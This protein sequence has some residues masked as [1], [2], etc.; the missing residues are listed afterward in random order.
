MTLMLLS[1]KI[2]GTLRKGRIFAPVDNTE[3]GG[4][5]KEMR[6]HIL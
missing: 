5:A 6:T 1:G 4:G 2:S 3:E